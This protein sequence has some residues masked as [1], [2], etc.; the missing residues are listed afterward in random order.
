MVNEEEEEERG[1]QRSS[2]LQKSSKSDACRQPVKNLYNDVPLR[3]T[4]HCDAI[5]SFVPRNVLQLITLFV[6]ARVLVAVY[7]HLA[8]K[9][10]S[11]I[12][13]AFLVA[14]ISF[15]GGS[16]LLSIGL[17]WGANSVNRGLLQKVVLGTKIRLVVLIFNSAFR[18]YI[19]SKLDPQDPLGIGKAKLIEVMGKYANLDPK[20]MVLQSIIYLPLAPKNLD[21]KPTEKEADKKD[22]VDEDAKQHQKIQFL[23]QNALQDIILF[24]VEVFI[25]Y[26]LDLFVKSLPQ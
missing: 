3:Y 23:V 7:P 17:I 9:E 15:N 21:K 1:T 11:A 25:V 13:T 10:G 8:T 20:T 19:V 18:L 6:A 12:D 26:R 5:G 2:I 16:C 4:S 22:K 24:F 14:F